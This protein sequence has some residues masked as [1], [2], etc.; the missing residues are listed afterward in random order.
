MLASQLYSI[1]EQLVTPNNP[2]RTDL[3][4]M[5]FE[6]CAALHNYLVDYCLATEGRL[7]LDTEGSRATYW[8]E[9]GTAAEALRP[10]LHHSMAA[11][12]ERAYMFDKTNPVFYFVASMR[13]PGD[14]LDNELADYENQPVDSLVVL[15]MASQESFDDDAGDGGLL[16]H[17]GRHRATFAVYP[18]DNYFV[19]PMDQRQQSWHFLETI[20]S[21]WIDLIHIGKV[22]ASP[23][24]KEDRCDGFKVGNWEWRP[25]GDGQVTSCIAAWD[26]LCHAI[27]VR[28]QQSEGANVDNEDFNEPLLPTTALD[29]ANIPDPSF[30]RD[31]LSLARRP[32]HIQQVAPGLS[33][34]PPN[35]TAFAAAQR[36]TN[37]PRRVRQWDDS[38]VGGIVPPV[39]ILFSENGAQQVNTSN[40]KSSFQYYWNNGQR[41]IPDAI[42]FPSSIPPGVYSECIVRFRAQATEEGFRLPLPF[43]LPGARYSDGDDI[44]SRDG[45]VDNLFQHGFKPLG[46]ETH[47]T[48]RLERLF[49]HFTSL[50]E[51]GVWSVGPHGVEGSIEV[52]KDAMV[53]WEVY[54]IP[55]SW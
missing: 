49:D 4:G 53:H 22:V 3:D 10:R 52:F 28:R 32:R 1:D 8:S 23:I 54:K 18:E 5:D 50:I 45:K 51:R 34:P 37:L 9:Y 41:K 33:L 43:A 30:V 35:A 46:G 12:L 7:G 19:F 31:F 11:F 29:A 24:A 16:Y 36:F 39:Y 13:L 2:P 42:P 14:L 47:R 26:R 20:L 55:S 38:W 40:W 44:Q 17:Q 48:Q 21:H 6:R 25:Y 27:E 15:Y